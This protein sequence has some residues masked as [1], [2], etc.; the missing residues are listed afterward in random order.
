ML[1]SARNPRITELATLARRRVRRERGQ[2]L[3]EGPRAVAEALD[4]GLVEEVFLDPVAASSL[5]IPAEVTVTE[6]AAHVL[7]RLADTRTPQGVVALARTPRVDLEVAIASGRVVV[8]HELADPG[9]AGTIL[10]TADAAG[11][12]GVV[13]TSGSVDP[14]GPKAVR[15][16][17]GS[18]Y[19]LAVVADVDLAEVAAACRSAGLRLIG[20]DAGAPLA[21]DHLAADPRPTALVLGNEAHG[22][23]AAATELLD[24]TVAVPIHGRAESLN[25]AAAAAIALYTLAR[26]WHDPT[27]GRG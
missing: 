21:V 14:F 20:L 22:L 2:H 12:G 9:N 24:A 8:L 13:L 10:R 5:T 25:V 27:S 11:A 26:R 16:A 6:V 19:H 18:T 3:V 15:A 7:A 4:A 1:T 23:D 17:A